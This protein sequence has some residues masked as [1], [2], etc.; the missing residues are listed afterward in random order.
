V[1]ALGTALSEA[2]GMFVLRIDARGMTLIGLVMIGR[3]VLRIK[4][5]GRARQ[6]EMMLREVPKRPLGIDDED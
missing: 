1:V 6:R 3:V 4:M 5:Q 2:L